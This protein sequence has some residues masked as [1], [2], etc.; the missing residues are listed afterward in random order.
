M[1]FQGTI[2]K[3]IGTICA[4][5]SIGK[6]VKSQEKTAKLAELDA[7]VKAINEY[8]S[9]NE[10]ATQAY[11]EHQDQLNEI[12]N[13]DADQ[14][15]WANEDESPQAMAFE[16]AKASV[17]NAIKAKIYQNNL[18]RQKMQIQDERWKILGVNKE[19]LKNLNS[20]EDQKKIHEFKKGVNW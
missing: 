9:N 5:A 1:S 17:Q 8:V 16:S 13:I 6:M 19:E 7:K 3:A 15:L 14:E 10:P 12:E 11:D 2:N 18:I 20:P 4:V